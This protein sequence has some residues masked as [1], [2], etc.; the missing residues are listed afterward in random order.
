MKI[1]KEIIKVSPQELFLEM[2]ASF[3]NPERWVLT[4]RKC[5]QCPN[6]P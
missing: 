5:L 2:M 4:V 6:Q 1:T 3:T